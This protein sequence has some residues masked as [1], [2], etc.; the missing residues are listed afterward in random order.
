[1]IQEYVKKQGVLEKKTVFKSI[2]SYWKRKI[3]HFDGL[4][5]VC[6]LMKC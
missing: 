1:M 6:L 4:S 3:I 5:M 2:E